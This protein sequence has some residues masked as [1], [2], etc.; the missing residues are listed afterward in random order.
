MKNI[1]SSHSVAWYD[2]RSAYLSEFLTEQRY[3]TLMTALDA[4][5]HYV[6]LLAE[7]T[8]HPHNASAL[9]RHCEAFGVQRMHIVAD[10]WDFNP[11]QAIVRGTDKWIDLCRHASTREALA[12]LRKEG[13]RIVATTPHASSCTPSNFDVASGR[14]VLVFGTEHAGI[15]EEVIYS[16]DEFLHIPMCGLVESLNVSASAAIL[17]SALTTRVRQEVAQWQLTA[18]EHAELRYRWLRVAVRDAEAVLA[19]RF[20]D[21]Q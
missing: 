16:A 15:S 18:V 19:R 17:L 7:N 9:M 3:R 6:T 14:F 1:A 5:T 12:S 21:E 13:Y 10:R 2:E 20:G 11:N 8:F 4:R